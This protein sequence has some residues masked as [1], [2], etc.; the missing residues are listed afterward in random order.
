MFLPCLWC[1]G[2]KPCV[3]SLRNQP[4]DAQLGFTDEKKWGY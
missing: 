3:F 4:M 2:S 1:A